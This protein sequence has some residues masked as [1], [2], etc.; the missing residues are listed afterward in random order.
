LQ[1]RIAELEKENLDLQRSKAEECREHVLTH[2]RLTGTSEALANVINSVAKRNA[3]KQGLIGQIAILESQNFKLEDEIAVQIQDTSSSQTKI[4]QLE[5]EARQKTI[6]M[7]TLL[8]ER[9]KLAKDD[10]H[11]RRDDE[12]HERRIS[13]FLADWNKRPARG[14]GA[15]GP[16]R[17]S[18]PPRGPRDPRGY[19]RKRDM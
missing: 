6:E 17:A 9:D 18:G 12:Q 1:A 2:G 16:Y 5:N 11:L 13:S 7:D 14:Q 15:Y 10:Q 3:E 19:E 8:C 4:Y